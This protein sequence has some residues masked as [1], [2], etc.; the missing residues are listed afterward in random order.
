MGTET[1]KKFFQKKIDVD[2]L[3]EPK[4]VAKR[5]RLHRN[6]CKTMIDAESIITDLVKRLDA[7][8]P[9]K[10]K[11][12]WTRLHRASMARIQLR[13]KTSCLEDLRSH[14]DE[15]L[16]QL[17]WIETALTWIARELEEA[18]ADDLNIR[19]H[20]IKADQLCDQLA[21]LRHRIDDFDTCIGL[22]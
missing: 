12:G 8:S 17:C 20:V 9:R 19:S 14:H 4:L 16:S 5:E 11:E 22:R 6:I 21:G 2:Y 3:D 13:S 10:R 15:I 7:V 1:L 18:R